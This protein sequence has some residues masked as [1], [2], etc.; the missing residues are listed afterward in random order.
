[1]ASTPVP[2]PPPPATPTRAGLVTT[3]A[4]S[5][6]GVK[7][8][9][10]NMVLESQLRVE[11][12]LAAMS[13]VRFADST[14]LSTAPV[15][16]DVSGYARKVGD[17]F[18]GAIGVVRINFEDG[19][20]Q[21]TA[22]GAAPDLTPYL[23]KAGGTM[24]GPLAVTR[25]D[26]PNGSYMTAAP[27]PPPDLTPYL[28]RAG[29]VMSGPL[30]MQGASGQ[31][32]NIFEVRDFIGRVG[33]SITPDGR[34]QLP[35]PPI[36]LGAAKMVT[37]TQGH[38]INFGTPNDNLWSDGVTLRT[39]GN[40]RL[41]PGGTL[42]SNNLRSATSEQTFYIIGTQ[43]DGGIAVA[44]STAT[45]HAN[46]NGKIF[47]F[48]NGGYPQLSVSVH[49]KLV[50]DPGNP[51]KAPGNIN[52]NG[53]AVG[54]AVIPAGQSQVRVTANTVFSSS[55]VRVH[56]QQAAHDATLQRVLGYVPDVGYFD[57]IGNAAA[58]SAVTVWWEICN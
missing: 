37:L 7:T 33:L 39:D 16:P 4:Q 43:P 31:T 29:G 27:P 5:F 28:P 10:A 23:A 51:G 36:G 26:F 11:G 8:F 1:M 50:R 2:S 54:W 55:L 30:Y 41:A 18:T 45:V 6:A 52:A 12:E 20:F 38:S 3:L 14:L 32:S 53:C 34:M 44:F 21:T 15:I 13:G 57:V 56:I 24:T 35:G 58:T 49:G 48:Q 47:S 19:T 46:P 42:F 22:P 17:N 40:F 9:I 25:L